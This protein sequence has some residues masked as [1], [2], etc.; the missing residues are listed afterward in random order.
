MAELAPNRQHSIALSASGYGRR[1]WPQ[2]PGVLARGLALLALAL[3]AA[4]GSREPLYAP[5]AE[6]SDCNSLADACEQVFEGEP[7]RESDSAAICTVRCASNRDCVADA[8]CVSGCSGVRNFCFPT[9]LPS[10]DLRIGDG[11]DIY[12]PCTERSECNCLA[13]ACFEV[14]FEDSGSV[15]AEGSFCSRRCAVDLDCP[16]GGG[17][18]EVEDSGTSICYARCGAGQGCAEGFVCSGVEARRLTDAICLPA[19]R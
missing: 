3:A 4:C 9:F 19:P 11:F 13:D 1:S 16:D 7:S 8:F 6:L 10:R 2:A 18:F 17:C 14:V 15:T 12:T 5:C